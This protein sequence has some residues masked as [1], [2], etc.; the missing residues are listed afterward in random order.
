MIPV[1]AARRLFAR[2]IASEAKQSRIRHPE[3]AAKRPSKDAAE[4]AI[5]IGSPDFEN[6]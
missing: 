5:E 4:A 1:L 6:V 3:V 2:V